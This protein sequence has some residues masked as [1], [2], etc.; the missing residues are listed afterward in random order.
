MTRAECRQL[1]FS[2]FSQNLTA[3]KYAWEGFPEVK[4]SFLCPEM[5]P[6]IWTGE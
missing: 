5:D 3:M 2:V 1:Y 4:D 6:K